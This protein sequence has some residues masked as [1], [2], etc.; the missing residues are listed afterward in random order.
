MKCELHLNKAFKNGTKYK[1]KLHLTLEKRA[2]RIKLHD[3]KGKCSYHSTGKTD[4]TKITITEKKKK[5]IMTH[6]NC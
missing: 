3:I 1:I 5:L 6:C 2:G 4:L